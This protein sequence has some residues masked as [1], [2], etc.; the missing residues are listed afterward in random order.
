MEE[1]EDF[2]FLFSNIDRLFSNKRKGHTKEDINKDWD[3]LVKHYDKKY[4][5]TI[6]HNATREEKPAKSKVGIAKD[7]L[8]K[9]LPDIPTIYKLFNKGELVYIGSTINLNNRAKDHRN[10]GKVFDEVKI[11]LV[12]EKEKLILE[13]HLIL[14]EQPPLNKT[15]DLGLA[16]KWNGTIPTFKHPLDVEAPLIPSTHLEYETMTYKDKFFL[17]RGI[18]IPKTVKPYYEVKKVS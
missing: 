3:L 9:V 18:L 8:V 12:S 7:L 10:A 6:L 14:K 15:V 5:F 17:C 4:L 1:D 16:K 13:N 11:T 2:E